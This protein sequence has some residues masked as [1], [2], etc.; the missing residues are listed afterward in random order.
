VHILVTGGAGY[1]GSIVAEQAEAAGHAVTVLD[2]LSVGKRGAVSDSWTFIEGDVGDAALLDELFDSRPVDAVVHLA[3]EAAIAPSMID[4]ALYFDANLTKGLA[5]LDAMRRHGVTR[6]VFSSTAATYGEP[7]QLPITEDHPHHPVNAYGESKYLFERC[8]EWYHRAYGLRAIVFRYFN[9]AGASAMRGED[10]P[11]ETHLIPL[12]LDVVLGRRDH[13]DVFGQDYATRDGSCLR[14]Y[15]HV[16][17]IGQAHLQ[18]IA[19]LDRVDFGRFNIGSGTG[20]TV[21]EV[22]NAVR[23]VTGQPLPIQLQPRRPGD[24]AALVASAARATEVLGWAPAH[25]SLDE[26]VESAWRWRVAHPLGYG[27]GQH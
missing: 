7:Q 15:V 18:A 8:L 27:N 1:I 26:I 17:D 22:V 2:N 16:A 10:R 24:P 25:P 6:L 4:P 3:A 23:R 20:H 14:D 9:A 21:L 12:A 5:L 13:L 19:A 11:H